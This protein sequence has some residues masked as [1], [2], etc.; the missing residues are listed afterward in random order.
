MHITW[1]NN[2]NSIYLHLM[3]TSLS[4]GVEDSVTSDFDL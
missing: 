1:K 3:T 2:L 4:L